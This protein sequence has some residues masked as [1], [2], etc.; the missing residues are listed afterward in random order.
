MKIYSPWK[1][2]FPEG[3]AQGKYDF[4]GGGIN[5]HISWTSMQDIVYFTERQVII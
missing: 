3:N 4:G 2:I 5:L 1:I